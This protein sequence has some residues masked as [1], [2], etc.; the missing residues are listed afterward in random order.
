LEGVFEAAGRLVQRVASAVQEARGSGVVRA[1][2]S[3]PW[4]AVEAG[5]GGG[6]RVAFV[7]T[8]VSWASE[9]P[10]L[11]IAFARPA[12]LVR[13]GGELRMFARGGVLLAAAAVPAPGGNRVV[14]DSEVVEASG[15]GG[16]LVHAAS[17]AVG[18]VQLRLS[19]ALVGY[20][21]PSSTA[22][23]ALE[24][25]VKALELA[26]AVYAVSRGAADY[27]VVDG[28]L[29]RVFAE[30]RAKGEVGL[31]DVLSTV[32]GGP[33]GWAALSRVVGLVK[34]LR[35]WRALAYEQVFS[36]WA[37]GRFSTAAAALSGG[38]AEAPTEEDAERAAAAVEKEVYRAAGLLAFRVPISSCGRLGAAEV[39]EQRPSLRVSGRVVEVDGGAA[40]E[41]CGRLLGALSEAYSK[42]VAVP[43]CPPKGFMEADRLSRV[44]TTEGRGFREAVRAA[45]RG[46]VKRLVEDAEE[47]RLGYR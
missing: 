26:Y 37:L 12:V 1:F 38:A 25:V 44:S 42:R 8:G 15:E 40:E 20:R 17:A 5:G 6:A 32:L 24:Y 27:A 35:D 36:R 23:K 46:L 21:A 39:F 3:L 7:D 19:R 14:L 18:E 16:E 47:M 2:T 45:S 29:Y 43:G 31:A 4:R 30:R 28:P 13:E 10:P 9:K 11:Y 34:S 22:R 41:A 33:A